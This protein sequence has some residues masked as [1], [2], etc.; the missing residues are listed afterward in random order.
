MKHD[1]EEAQPEQR[2]SEHPSQ[3][4]VIGPAREIVEHLGG[5]TKLSLLLLNVKDAPSQERPQEP[6]AFEHEVQFAFSGQQHH[7]EQP[8]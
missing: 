1:V 6:D 8:R 2:D 7:S 4:T 5:K 3:D